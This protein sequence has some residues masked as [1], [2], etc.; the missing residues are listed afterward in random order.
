MEAGNCA[1]LVAIR[2]E[3]GMKNQEIFVSSAHQLAD[4]GLR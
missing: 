1:H 4:G 3:V 2:D